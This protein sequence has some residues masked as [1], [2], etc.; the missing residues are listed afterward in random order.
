M[1]ARSGWVFGIG[2]L[3]VAAGCSTPPADV[4]EAV[5]GRVDQSH[6]ALTQTVA[7]QRGTRGTVAD[8]YVRAKQMTASFGSKPK[9][10]VSAFSEGLVRFDLSSIPANAVVDSASLRL[11]AHGEND[12][13][14]DDC[15]DGDREGFPAVPIRFHRVTGPWTESSTYA[16]FGQR[17]DPAVA[18]VL[19][20]NGG[21]A[22]KTV[23]VTSL[24]RAWV[25]GT[26]P[27]YGV[28]LRTTS[29]KPT[30]FVSSEGAKVALRPMLTVS[31]TTPDDHCAPNPCVQ[32]TCAN[33]QAGYTCTC[34]PGFTGPRCDT[35]IDNCASAP[36]KN[37]GTCTTSGATYACACAPGFS[38][39]N[40][41]I[42]VD[43]CAAR[44]CQNGG[45]CTD[46]VNA[47][48][49]ACPPGYT[50]ETCGTLVDNCASNPCENGGTCT[51][52]V[53]SYTC[54]CPAGFT[55]VNCQINVDD[56][57]GNPCQN[58][59][60]CADG[61]AS[62]TCSCA[63]GYT[64]TN[65][66]RLID[67]CASAPC[68]NGGTC[69][70]RV[71]DYAC[72]CA[73]GF[74]GRN[75][76]IDIDDCATNPCQ[77]EG[78]C[79]DGVSS[80]TCAC[81]RGYMGARCELIDPNVCVGDLTVDTPFSLVIPAAATSSTA[82]F[83]VATGMRV[84]VEVTSGGPPRTTAIVAPDGS[85]AD[86]SELAQSYSLAVDPAY[87]TGLYAFN[88]A[89]TSPGVSLTTT[90]TLRTLPPP[91]SAS[92]TVD[93]P[94]VSLALSPT[95][96]GELTFSGVAGQRIGMHLTKPVIGS[97]AF[98][99][100]AP[101]GR[102]VTSVDP[103]TV[104]L[105]G[106]P[107]GPYR[108][109]ESGMHRIRYR[110]PF[111]G[112]AMTLTTNV[113]TV[114]EDP[115]VNV[116][117]DGGPVTLSQ[118][119]DFQTL[120]FALGL[121]AGRAVDVSIQSPVSVYQLNGIDGFHGSVYFEGVMPALD[122]GAV[123]TVRASAGTSFTIQASTP[124]FTP[125]AG[126]GTPA[127][128]SPTASAAL[129]LVDGGWYEATFV[130]AAPRFSFFS[131][132]ALPASE[133]MLSNSVFSGFAAAPVT[134]PFFAPIPG[135]F[136]FVSQN[137]SASVSVVKRPAPV[138]EQVVGATID[139][140]VVTTTIPVAN[141]TVRFVLPVNEG[142]EAAIRVASSTGAISVNGFP[143]AVGY[144]LD[145]VPYQTGTSSWLVASSTA[146]SMITFEASTPSDVLVAP[147]GAEVFVP[148]GR[149]ARLLAR[150]AGWYD[151]RVSRA[152]T[153]GSTTVVRVPTINGNS[154]LSSVSGCV[155][156]QTLSFY[157]A[158]P[159]A[160]QIVTPVGDS[161][162]GV[163]AR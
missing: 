81:P 91:V 104:V 45:V 35:P 52:G 109:T 149:A 7:F 4:G 93:G 50:G 141:G 63:P 90:V 87:A 17:F 42:N 102:R 74:S 66:E 135:R 10:R 65:C 116:P 3:L 24:V 43:D 72:T 150:T 33:G 143:A 80:F 30:L 49:C 26:A 160:Y 161:T 130:P 148:A 12:E 132:G 134:V 129:S 103:G 9:M 125:I 144:G 8:T 16:S 96:R 1:S 51:N 13:D 34:N 15:D 140:G 114:P 79:V 112:S 38:G 145:F 95:D 88:V 84:A 5:E 152:S 146:G 157:V 76:E 127:T 73:P 53:G 27:N 128:V 19:V 64:G 41:E 56:C 154:L 78:V 99:I 110:R 23:N 113:E 156:S 119:S 147:G 151:A 121:E 28:L 29:K 20:P 22:Y 54:A 137:G 97:L 92:L 122:G 55:G 59:G 18:A 118:V 25:A 31:Y 100:V 131:V 117:L 62:Y 11:Y 142:G 71:N 61:V 155:A 14:D 89:R 67:N 58:G 69:T 21:S 136:A 98:D 82:T 57:A 153:C 47:F 40:C 107:F 138:G 163:T 111:A 133:R 115:I 106:A 120:R 70:N 159:G 139:G 46:G 68:Q 85:I 108:L 48:S 75:C 36:C 124:V 32:G 77:N 105:T 44:P 86:T 6:Q 60:T 39:T 123:W 101:S 83:C 126:L 2:A 37:G 158:I 94:S 162:V